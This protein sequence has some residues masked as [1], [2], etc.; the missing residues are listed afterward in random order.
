[1]GIMGLRVEELKFCFGGSRVPKHRS[2]YY[3]GILGPTTR[4]LS[5]IRGS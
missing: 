5:N 4:C 3:R 2:S 1:M